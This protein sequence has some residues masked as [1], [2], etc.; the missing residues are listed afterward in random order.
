M[1]ERKEDSMLYLILSVIIVVGDQFVKY[2]TTLNFSSGE[3]LD[4]IPSVFRLT[5]VENTGGAFS[6][7]SDKSW[8][9]WVL[10]GISAVAIIAIIII[11]FK[12]R[13]GV[14][15][16]LSLCFILGG[17]VGNLIDRLVLGYVVDMFQPLFINF[18]VF[19]V[20]D[21]FITVG[22]ILLVIYILFVHKWKKK[23]KEEPE[24]SE[25]ASGVQYAPAVP[26][27]N[28]RREKRLS[29]KYGPDI[30]E[31]TIVIPVDKIRSAAGKDDISGEAGADEAQP[32]QKE[33]EAS[34][35]DEFFKNLDLDIEK[36]A[37]EAKPGETK[38]DEDFTFE[39]IMR[40][41]GSDKF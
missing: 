4:V 5:Y 13:L 29:K 26:T 3:S 27:G 24:I 37:Q 20:A 19:N 36:K 33:E 18:A 9:I 35:E 2:L 25:T 21:I 39:D 12:A 6:M 16:K 31:S 41:F 11:M 32:V 28:T 38:S 17:A 23:G 7:F 15:G 1:Q 34:P 30:D 8:G 14:L 40:E 22:G 10:A